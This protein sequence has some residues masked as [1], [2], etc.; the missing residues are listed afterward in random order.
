[1]KERKKKKPTKTVDK[2]CIALASWPPSMAACNFDRV[3]IGH[4]KDVARL[5]FFNMCNYA[6]VVS[7]SWR[8]RPKLYQLPEVCAGNREVSCSDPILMTLN[9][10]AGKGRTRLRGWKVRLRDAAPHE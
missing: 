7:S 10:R 3:R 4:L 1:M 2:S 5:V 9:P 8:R 6:D